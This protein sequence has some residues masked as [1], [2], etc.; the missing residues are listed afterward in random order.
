MLLP[1]ALTGTWT[2]AWIKFPLTIPGDVFAFPS[3]D[4]IGAAWVVL[5]I[6]K[7]TRRSRVHAARETMLGYE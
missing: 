1:H 4:S 7:A 2:G 3:L 6:A 5:E